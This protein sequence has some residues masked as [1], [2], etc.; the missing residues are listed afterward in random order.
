MV[1]LIKSCVCDSRLD[2]IPNRKVLR[3]FYRVFNVRYR[4]QEFIQILAIYF[5]RHG[6]GK[7]NGRDPDIAGPVGLY[8]YA[9]RLDGAGRDLQYRLQLR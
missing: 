3:T 4:I 2:E 8:Q 9:E 7:R 1:E 5:S 6:C